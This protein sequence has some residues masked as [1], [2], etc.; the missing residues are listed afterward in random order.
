[1]W[2]VIEEMSR[3]TTPID[4]SAI[5]SHTS[6]QENIA[7]SCPGARVEGCFSLAAWSIRDGPHARLTNWN[8]LEGTSGSPGAGD[9]A[10]DAR[11]MN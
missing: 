7:G 6:L 5:T 8:Y 10:G 4:E 2:D 9:G 11:G 1:M 3:G